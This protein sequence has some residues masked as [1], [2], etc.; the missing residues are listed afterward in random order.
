MKLKKR[1][2]GVAVGDQIKQLI[3]KDQGSP[4]SMRS[5]LAA[6]T[7]KAMESKKRFTQK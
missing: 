5:K 2:R 4:K 7:Q 3:N 1:N 6:Q